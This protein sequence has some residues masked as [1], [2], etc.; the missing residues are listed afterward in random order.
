MKKQI[1]EIWSSRSPAERTMAAGLAI[2]IGTLLCLWFIHVAGQQRDRLKLSISV[3]KS[4]SAAMEQHTSEFGRLQSAPAGKASPATKDLRETMQSMVDSAGLSTSLIKM[5]A[6]D[7]GTVQISFG[8]LSF[9]DW[10]AFARNLQAQQIRIETCRI[11][12]LATAGRVSI[13]ATVSSALA[14]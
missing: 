10:L 11:E 4:Q 1:L 9:A 2:V 12:A 6:Q 13:T 7:A 8:A 5:D 14:R 3:L